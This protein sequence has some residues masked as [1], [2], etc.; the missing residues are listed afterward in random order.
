MI[1]AS[2][3]PLGGLRG[4]LDRAGDLAHR[5]CGVV[6][7]KGTTRFLSYNATQND[8][9]Q[10][11]QMTIRTARRCTV[12]AS[13]PGTFRSTLYP[14]PSTAVLQYGSWRLRGDRGHVFHQSGRL[15]RG[16]AGRHDRRHRH[17]GHRHPSLGT[18]RPGRRRRHW[19]SRRRC[20]GDPADGHVRGR[21]YC[22]LFQRRGRQRGGGRRD[23]DCPLCAR[24]HVRRNQVFRVSLDSFSGTYVD[25]R[26][27]LATWAKPAS[28][29]TGQRPSG[30]RRAGRPDVLRHD[31][32]RPFCGTAPAGRG[33][34]QLSTVISAPL[35]P[36]SCRW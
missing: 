34:N 6:D 4:Q 24:Q 29:T 13:S 11:D 20:A 12:R 31:I 7:C 26:T 5:L 8:G 32:Q 10:V 23:G 22:D 36:V 33:Y 16:A 21:H 2:S 18:R 19:R 1:V 28:G 14:R 27:D 17:S 15:V 3:V 25:T 30:S 35:S 9:T